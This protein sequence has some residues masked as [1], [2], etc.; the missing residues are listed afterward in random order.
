[1]RLY[2]ELPSTKVSGCGPSVLVGWPRA[3]TQNT[4][5]YQPA[6]LK[7]T[8]VRN[9][10]GYIPETHGATQISSEVLH[11]EG[12]TTTRVQQYAVGPWHA[13]EELARTI[14]RD[15]CH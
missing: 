5:S 7:I 12:I 15:M 13:K 3:Q 8:N 1:M 2:S 10:S 6:P 9:G 14:H 11:K 4:I